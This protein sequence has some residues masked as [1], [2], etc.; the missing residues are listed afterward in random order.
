MNWRHDAVYLLP[1]YAAD[2]AEN[3]FAISRENIEKEREETT[4]DGTLAHLH[5]TQ[6]RKR[7]SNPGKLIF[8]TIS[9]F[10]SS[11]SSSC[12]RSCKLKRKMYDCK[13]NNKHGW[14][15]TNRKPRIIGMRM[16]S[17]FYSSIHAYMRQI[18]P[19]FSIH[20]L[21]CKRFVCENWE[22]VHVKRVGRCTLSAMKIY[23]YFHYSCKNWSP[24]GDGQQR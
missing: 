19:S 11:P 16:K 22:C 2:T 1:A 8:R 23:S 7:K 17:L 15:W 12:L 13:P 5:I 18:G 10:S 14:K 9:S 6:N 20:I 24:S 3:R 4:I 21:I